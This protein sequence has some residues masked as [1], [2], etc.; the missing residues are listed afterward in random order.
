MAKAEVQREQLELDRLKTETENAGMALK[1][2]KS[3]Y[4]ELMDHYDGLIDEAEENLTAIQERI[5]SSEK[6]LAQVKADAA[7]FKDPFK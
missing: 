2:K 3:N 4:Q 1:F 7:V 6:Q 5:K